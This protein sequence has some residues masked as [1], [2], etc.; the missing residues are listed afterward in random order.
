MRIPSILSNGYHRRPNW[1][2]LFPSAS[3]ELCR[4]S[5]DPRL[6]P[7]LRLKRKEEKTGSDVNKQYLHEVCTDSSL[8]I[9][10]LDLLSLSLDQR[11]GPADGF[12]PFLASHP[13]LISKSSDSWRISSMIPSWKRKKV[14]SASSFSESHC[15]SSL[16]GHRNERWT[17]CD[18]WGWS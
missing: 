8:S 9:A 4:S 16:A 18:C 6:P 2:A 14:P 3:P 13:A 12:P 5:S 7:D 17:W 10:L 11:G 15:L 1:G